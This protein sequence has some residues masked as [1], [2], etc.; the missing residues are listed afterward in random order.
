MARPSVG[1][2][3]PQPGKAL[4]LSIIQQP[5]IARHLPDTHSIDNRRPGRI[6]SSLIRPFSMPNDAGGSLTNLPATL[7][8]L[9]SSGDV[10]GAAPLDAAWRAFVA[11]HSKL[12]LHVARSIWPNHDDAMD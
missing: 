2:A 12:L 8:R 11:E 6:L 1:S 9:L 4:Q 5:R 10:G 7:S 3:G